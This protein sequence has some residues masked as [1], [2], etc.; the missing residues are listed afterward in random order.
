MH[1]LSKLQP[2]AKLRVRA[3]LCSAP[4]R[5][6]HLPRQALREG[7]QIPVAEARETHRHTRRD[8]RAGGQEGA[9]EGSAQAM[10]DGDGGVEPGALCGA[11]PRDGGVPQ[12]RRAAEL[13]VH[14]GRGGLRN[15]AARER[16]QPQGRHL[17]VHAARCLPPPWLGRGEGGLRCGDIRLHEPHPGRP[18]W[19]RPL[20]G[21]R[22]R[23]HLRIHILHADAATAIWAGTGPL[24]CRGIA[25]RR[26]PR[27]LLVHRSDL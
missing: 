6:H 24:R 9:R 14:A 10:D 22:R 15:R 4:A 21:K 7:Q 19:R 5:I 16:R 18:L 11:H 2:S 3:F 12:R 20:D 13:E 8:A 1:L 25:N 26:G 23:A 27:R 17:G